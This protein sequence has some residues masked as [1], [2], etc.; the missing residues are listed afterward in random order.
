MIERLVEFALKQRFLVGVIAL[1][2][3]GYGAYAARKLPIDAFPD[4][5]N[6]QVQINSE[7]PGLAAVEVEK[8]I[9]FPIESVMNGLPKVTEVRSMSKTGLSVVTVVFED[10]VDIYFARNLVLERLQV[11]KERIP[12]GLADPEI[13]PITTGLGQIYQ[14]ILEGEGASAQE[15]R[16]I[17]DWIVKPELRTVPGVTDVLSF[18][19]HVRQYQV[20]IHPE[21]LLKYDLTL[22][23]VSE[24]I[25]QS[26]RNAGGWYVERGAEQLVVRGVGLIRGGDDGLFDIEHVVVK[27]LKG[28]PV[29][30]RDVA[31]VVYGAEIRQGAVTKD[32]KG[33]VVSGIV[34]QLRGA[35]TKEVIDRVKERVKTLRLPKGV[36]LSPYYDQADLVERA[37]G[38]VR[39]AL[40]EAGL[41]I[42]VVLFLFL[43][44]VRSAFVVVCSIPISLLIA[45]IMMGRQG[46]SANLQSLGGLAIGIGMMVD[47]S[48][49]MV[50]N[51]FRHLAERK[52][53]HGDRLSTVLLAA[54][55][56]A[57][58]VFFAV[59]I[60]IVVFLP[61][62]TLQGVEGKLFAPMAFSISFAML[63]S[64]LVALFVVPALSAWLLGGRLSEKDSFLVR[65]LK[66][67]YAPCL[68]WAIGHR[69]P[70]IV[71]G[72][73]LLGASAGA[74]KFLG[75]EFVPQLEEG[76]IN[77]R[78]TMN[79]SISL[80]E[81][82]RIAARLEAK[83]VKHEGIAYALSRIGRAELGG[84]PESV[85]N[86]EIYVG[87][88]PDAVH[89][90]KELEKALEE[91]LEEIP[92]LLFSFSQPIATRVDELL[93]G[94]KAEIAVKLY[95][96]DL[97]V[98]AEKGAAIQSLISGIRGAEGVQLEQISGEAQ[99]VIR[100]DR[101]AIAQ[102]G[103]NVGDVMD[104][105]STAV[106]GEKLGQVLDGEKR[107]DI[108]M[109]VAAQ[110]RRDKEE[111]ERLIIE[112]PSGAHVPLGRV[113]SV[114][115]EEGP[116]LVSREHARRRVV[117]Q[118]NVR[119]RD[120]GGFVEEGKKLLEEKLIP[121]LPAG[122]TIE[123]GGQ[124]ENQERAQRTLMIVVPLSIF[125][126]FV[127]LVMSF[128][129]AKPALLIILNVP[130][131]MIGGV[132]ALLL[133]GQYLSVPSSIGFI[134]VF[135]VAVLNGVVLVSY[136][137]QL[138][139]GGAPPAVAAEKGALMRMRPVLMTAAV[140][141]LGL[142]PLLISK[143]IGSEVQRPL[144]TVVVGGLL[145]STLLT[146][147]VL[148]ACYPWFAKET[149]RA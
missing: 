28:T 2:V 91:D 37:I 143:G 142:I 108:Y 100:A 79:P 41:L 75:T 140:A 44:N 31:D 93:S 43:W 50:E 80:N 106:G 46:I 127:L 117:V 49:V 124:F 99:L 111:I 88:K 64:L 30:V 3:L 10:D 135:G 121:S 134:A 8:L 72:V 55:E 112:S 83:I 95:G 131:S 45:A 132:F 120:L 23:S 116:P 68:R 34:L 59:L 144:A 51:I 52:E 9:T 129:R 71:G 119:G 96:E 14:Y 26:N 76:T 66:F 125:L 145:S 137:E 27:H 107:F 148:P 136:I 82:V 13:G 102:Q 24:K 42:L 33:E 12:Q 47:G 60:I 94:V 7:A 114:E 118:T 22:S 25:R 70:V 53:G 84:D 89:R 56:V 40:A 97:D 87:L 62:F 61:L 54:R 36:K 110:Y 115:V 18:G 20:N 38:T 63:G 32:G 29:Y 21:K 139:L 130:F 4:V 104:T 39:K 123:W 92:G 101:S 122:Y 15:L 35:N 126:I 73:L 86:N 17:N 11:A 103:L 133:S 16:T 69:M 109:R 48:V 147:L 85:S 138:Q 146:L 105:I 1:S 74:F 57:R 77:I 141:M 78:V 65:G 128:G 113:A 19:G 81:A 149:P 98:L 58:P 67:V 90:R 6:V 5:T